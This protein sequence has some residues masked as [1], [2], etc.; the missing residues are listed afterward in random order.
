MRDDPQAKPP[1]IWSNE[2]QPVPDDHLILAASVVLTKHSG[3]LTA[4]RADATMRE[5]IARDWVAQ[6]RRCGYR[7]T[8]GPGA[9]DPGRMTAPTNEGGDNA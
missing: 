4:R 7:I 1:S 3:N 6:L 5:I 9:P 8:F 2:G